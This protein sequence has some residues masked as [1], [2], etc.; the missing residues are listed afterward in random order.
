MKKLTSEKAGV[1]TFLII[2][3][4]N[5]M[6]ISFYIYNRSKVL[7]TFDSTL[8]AHV[9]KMGLKYISPEYVWN[10]KIL[11]SEVISNNS[12]SVHF[13]DDDLKDD[14][15]VIT[16]RDNFVKYRYKKEIPYT[17]KLEVFFKSDYANKMEVTLLVSEAKCELEIGGFLIKLAV[18]AGIAVM[19]VMDFR[20]K[21]R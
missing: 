4:I 5:C 14:F 15:E 1:Y 19:L 18:G 12:L 17:S 11:I 20:N 9:Q 10:Q 8:S 7:H 6:F 3:L 16:Q 21:S 2:I 13:L